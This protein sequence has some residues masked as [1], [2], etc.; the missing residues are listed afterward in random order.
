[1]AVGVALM[2][3]GCGG[4]GASM[5]NEDSN[6]STRAITEPIPIEAPV[7]SDDEKESYLKAINDARSQRQDCGEEGVFD[8]APPLQWNE[9]LYKAAYEHDRD[10]VET[11]MHP[12]SHDGSGTE[13]DHTAQEQGL[14]YSTFRDRIENNGYTNWKTIG[15]NIAAGT[16]MDTAE[17]AVQAWLASDGHCAN[18]MNP[19]YRDVGM[20]HIEKEGAYYTHY[21]TQDFGA[22]K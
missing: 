14:E 7:L 5:V 18:L 17:K 21:W 16:T 12:L 19:D 15:E 9:D 3:S 4:G 10:M 2:F 1:M 8:P 22:K 13:Y 11:D 6:G 20:A